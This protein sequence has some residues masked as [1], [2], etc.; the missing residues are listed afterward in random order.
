MSIKNK[1]AQYK[2]WKSG[3][4]HCTFN[5]DGPGV[6]RIHLI[7]PKFKLF[8]NA[9]YL[10]ILNGYYILPL[11]YSWALMLSAF[12]DEVNEFDGVEIS[13]GEESAIISDTV[14][15]LYTIV[16]IF[17]KYSFETSSSV[18]GVTLPVDAL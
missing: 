3:V 12:I 11:G 4:K 1:I 7:P 17:S 14:N 6:V 8:S 16:D 13:D 15:L 18:S 5:P 10:V 2:E 9:E